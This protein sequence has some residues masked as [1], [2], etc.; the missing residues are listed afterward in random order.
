MQLSQIALWGR[1]LILI[2]VALIMYSKFVKFALHSWEN[3]DGLG[4]ILLLALVLMLPML[5]SS[6]GWTT[7]TNGSLD[8]NTGVFRTVV[9]ENFT[10]ISVWES[11][12]QL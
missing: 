2:S 1:S 9:L 11:I 8:M 12:S 5:W 3:L 7:L 10:N 6:A 4:D